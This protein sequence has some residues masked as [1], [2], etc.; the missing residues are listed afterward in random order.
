MQS[1]EAMLTE[2]AEEDLAAEPRAELKRQTLL[3]KALALYEELLKVEPDDPG[4]AWL[5]ARAARRV[6]D[7]QRLLG[8]YPEALAA[9]DR[10]LERLA[11]LER[12]PPPGTDPT[13]EIADVHNFVGEVYR[14]RGEP[15]AA[16]EAY[17]RALAIQQPALA[18]NAAHEDYR[19][20]LSRTRYNLGLVARQ[21]GQ[22]ALAVRELDEAARLLDGLPADDAGVRHHR[23]RILVNLG[24]AHWEN[25]RP[26]AE[27]ACRDAIALFDTLVAD[28]GGRPDLRWERSAAVFNLGL[29]LQSA[30]DT[31]GARAALTEARDVL[32]GLVG[33]FKATPQYRADLAQAY[34]GLA[35]L[36]F[37]DHARA[38]RGAFDALAVVAGQVGSAAEAAAMSEKAAAARAVLVADRGTPENHGAL[39][40]SLG[41]QGLALERLDPGR[42]RDLLTR[43][44]TELL[45]G[46]RTSPDDPGFR[47]SLRKQTR[48]VAWLLV[49]AGDHDAAHALARRIAAEPP[50]PVRSAHRAAALLAAC[51]A[52]VERR[53]AAGADREAERYVR[54]AVELVT[55]AGPAA[56]KALA[57]DADC[58]PLVGHRAFAAAL[59]K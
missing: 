20:D 6:G 10:A 46:M 29:V 11:P 52:A 13:R 9:Y 7:I 49:R 23:A 26:E 43:G 4:L 37:D 55:A 28:G 27:R 17:G 41:N 56:W 48:A 36:A 45:V 21:M 16:R 24:V 25:D 3:K 22:P 15:A 42:A 18:A 58:A 12:E 44:L 32:A 57:A 38:A 50:D 47:D 54:L 35:G 1:I 51:L 33:D 5:A 19:K 30:H 8:R 53:K 59:E 39:G 31:A 34:D 40:V 14:L 2:V